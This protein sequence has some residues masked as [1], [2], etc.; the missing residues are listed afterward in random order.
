MRGIYKAL[1]FHTHLN[2][3]A[4]LYRPAHMLPRSVTAIDPASLVMT[5]FN[6]TQPFTIAPSATIA[7]ANDKMIACG[8]RLLFVID[9]PSKLVGLI[10]ATDILGERPL[11]YIS[12]H[13]GTR[14]GILV[15]DIMTAREKIQTLTM[16]DVNHASVGDIVETM[17]QF[18]R[19]H[20]LVIER[21]A[22]DT[23]MTV[24]GMFS[25]TQIARQLGE[26]IE[27]LPRA[28]TFAEMELAITATA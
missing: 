15:G 28:A 1:P 24:R 25:T 14:D 26:T 16:D 18:G 10:T 23:R 20:I 7:Q 27:A 19:Q 4:S 13:G 2:S 3:G 8:V 12:E 11:L 22:D 21:Y 9:A 5:D 6:I 17:K